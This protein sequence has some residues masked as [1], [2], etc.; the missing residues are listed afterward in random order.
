MSGKRRVKSGV[1]MY[2]IPIA[3]V[4]ND[5]NATPMTKRQIVCIATSTIA[6]RV[7]DVVL[8]LQRPIMGRITMQSTCVT[9]PNH[10]AAEAVS[11]R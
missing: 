8:S 6:R 4:A 5:E 7:V 2:S 11:C 1:D 9:P 3:A 10:P